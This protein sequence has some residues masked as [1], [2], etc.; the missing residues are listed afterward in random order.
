M[1]KP[2]NTEVAALSAVT[3]HYTPG[4]VLYDLKIVNNNAKQL[5][6]S[7]SYDRA[8]GTLSVT[9]TETGV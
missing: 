1:V 9:V 8:S 3:L 4:I 2:L 7:V 6:A 5:A